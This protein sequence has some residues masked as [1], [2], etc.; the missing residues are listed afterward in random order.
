MPVWK[1]DFSQD[2]LSHY[3]DR[4][5][6]I[7]NIATLDSCI[8]TASIDITEFLGIVN[9]CDLTAPDLLETFAEAGTDGRT[10]LAHLVTMSIIDSCPAVFD[11]ELGAK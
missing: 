3:E 10:T 9:N 1:L 6:V 4:H 8:V 7:E 5:S 2:P 11:G